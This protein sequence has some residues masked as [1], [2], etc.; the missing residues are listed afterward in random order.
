MFFFIILAPGPKTT[1][2]KKNFTQNKSQTQSARAYEVTSFL[3]TDYEL[4]TD[5]CSKNVYTG[6]VHILE[7]LEYTGI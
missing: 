1:K 3:S 7:N 6:F 5:T 2:K 4:S